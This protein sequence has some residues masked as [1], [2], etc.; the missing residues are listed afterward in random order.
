MAGYVAAND[1]RGDVDVIHATELRDLDPN[2]VIILDVRTK[3]EY[4]KGHIKGVKHI[5]VDELREHLDDISKDMLVILC[6]AT[7]FRSY[8]A[9]RNLVQRGVK[10][11][12]LCGGMNNYLATAEIT[13]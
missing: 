11:F 6:C 4:D 7:G 13:R 10:V 12:N 8:Y 3:S 5:Y 9:Y 2:S 1:L